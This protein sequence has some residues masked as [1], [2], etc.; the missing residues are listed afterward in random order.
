MSGPKAS[1]DN[2][3][4]DGDKI[5]NDK[6]ACPLDSENDRDSDM[7]CFLTHCVDYPVESIFGSCKNYAPD[8][9]RSSHDFCAKDTVAVSQ[10]SRI[11]K[12]TS[13]CDAC[14]CSC[15]CLNLMNI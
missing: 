15:N 2:N 13:M 8:V 7:V 11:A 3:D 14:L 4:L 10:D 9:R 12:G 6:D 1:V 5:L